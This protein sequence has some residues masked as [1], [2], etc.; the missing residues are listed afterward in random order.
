M[1]KYVYTSFTSETTI[2]IS[3]KIRIQGSVPD[4]VHF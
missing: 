4:A 1:E 3:T 2:Q